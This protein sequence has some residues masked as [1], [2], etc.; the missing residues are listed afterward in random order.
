VVREEKNR[1]SAWGS[2]GR[3]LGK[4]CPD[5]V[6]TPWAVGVFSL[7]YPFPDWEG[8]QLGRMRWGGG[9]RTCVTP[10]GVKVAGFPLRQGGILALSELV[11]FPGVGVFWA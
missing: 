2:G 11:G 3:G 1:L 9:L 7:A 10:Q 4:A 8:R 5:A 6:A